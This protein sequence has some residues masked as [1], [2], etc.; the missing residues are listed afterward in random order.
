MSRH[1]FFLES[2]MPDSAGGAA[3][4]VPLR[5]ADLHHA[6]GVLRVRSGEEIDVVAPGGRVWRVVVTAA[7]PEALAGRIAEELLESAGSD[8]PQ[9]TLVFGVSKGAK[10]D[11]IVEGAVEVGVAKLMPALTARSI[12]RYDAEKRVER[13]DRWRRVALAAAKQAKRSAV[14]EVSDPVALD[15]AVALLAGY[16][17]V[18]VAWE[19]A[20]AE[21][22]GIRAAIEA[23]GPMPLAA[24]V[25]VVVGPEGGLASE[26]V[27]ALERAG[28]VVVTLGASIL[29]AET[30]A[31]VSAALVLH[32]LGG[33]GN[34][35]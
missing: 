18:V 34:S 35:R 12:V 1:R 33:L 11:D 20:A 5:S 24:R 2:E 9:V 21:G 17:L 13:G 10:N 3:C 8:A 14:P 16:D 27:L 32:E 28:A 6:V 19:E 23:A 4:F 22:D 29:R 25:A 15:D 31:V 30:A 26:E 7:G